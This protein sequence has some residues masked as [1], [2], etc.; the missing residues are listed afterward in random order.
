MTTEEL[1][2]RR[3]SALER[4]LRALDQHLL[5]ATKP[6]LDYTAEESDLV[7][8]YLVLSHA[9]IEA[10]LEDLARNV[11]VK[12]KERWKSAGRARSALVAVMAYHEG[13]LGQPAKKLL[14][15]S[16]QKPALTLDQRIKVAC[17]AYDDYARKDNHGVR[18]KNLLRLLLPVGVREEDLDLS[19]VAEMDSF[20]IQRGRVAHGEAKSV[21]VQIDPD[22]A[23]GQV[24]AIVQGLRDLDGL[25][26]GLAR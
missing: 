12:A 26:A 23:R 21:N 22:V 5:P 2:T 17:D 1:P 13:N 3:L 4:R 7:R 19:W 24:E 25:L 6:N 8:S 20:G 14:T 15:S 11:L 9:E 18:E 10:C 16:A